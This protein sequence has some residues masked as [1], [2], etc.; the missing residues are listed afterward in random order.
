MHTCRI[1]KVPTVF[2]MHFL[3]ISFG[4]DKGIILNTASLLLNKLCPLAYKLLKCTAIKGVWFFVKSVRY[5][6]LYLVIICEF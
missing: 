6:L 3:Y 1:I 2:H 5:H 4:H